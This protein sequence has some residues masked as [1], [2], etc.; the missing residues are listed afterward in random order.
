MT[1]ENM[2]V[3]TKMTKSMAMVFS[4]GLTREYYLFHY[5]R[6]TKVIGSTE[7]NTVEE[8]ILGLQKSKK[9]ENGSM[10][11]ELNGSRETES[12]SMG[13]DQIKLAYERFLQATDLLHQII[14]FSSKNSFNKFKEI[15]GLALQT[16]NNQ[17]GS[18]IRVKRFI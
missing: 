7:N 16:I 11:K 18:H 9:K 15:Y 4:N 17:A 8:L 10:V 13:M 12:Q 6:F 1:A 2:L 5:L 14:Y 3:N